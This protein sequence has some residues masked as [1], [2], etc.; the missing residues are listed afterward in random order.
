MGIK[1]LSNILYNRIPLQENKKLLS[2][3]TIRGES[4][5]TEDKQIPTIENK[6]IPSAK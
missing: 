5:P 6:K 4:K 1:G 2:A 3:T